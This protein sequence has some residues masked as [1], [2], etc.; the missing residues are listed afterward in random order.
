MPAS[1]TITL[2]LSIYDSEDALFDSLVLIDN[3]KWIANAEGTITEAIP[4]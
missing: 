4:R 3:F 1:E 2:R